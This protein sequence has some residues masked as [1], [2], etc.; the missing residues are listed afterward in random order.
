MSRYKI[1][2]GGY[3]EYNNSRNLTIDFIRGI[4]IL[5]VVFGHNIQYGSG[6]IFIQSDGYFEEILFKIIYS[7][8]MPLFALLSGYLFFCSIKKSV[9]TVL[10]TRLTSLL[11]PIVCWVALE[12]IVKLIILLILCRFNIISFM[13]DFVS[14]AVYR[15]WFLWAI[16]W[17]SMIVLLVEKIFKGRVWIYI[18][19][20]FL[21][22][23]IPAKYNTQM[24]VYMYPYFV[25]GFLFNKFEGKNWY[26]RIV[27]KDWIALAVA[28]VVFVVLFLFYDHDSY[29]YTTGIN[30][31]A[32]RSVLLQLG[33]DI[34]RWIIGF[35]GSAFVIVLCKMICDKGQGYGVKLFAYFGQISLGIYILNSYVNSYVLQRI[36]RNFSP[37]VF[38]WIV[39]TI[40]SMVF[41]AVAVEIIKKVPAAN[42]LLL[43]GR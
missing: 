10:K 34:Y 32:K 23:F 15:L 16:F 1:N 33:I 29:I 30:I 18:V 11:L 22:L 5:L 20:M 38:I 9:K 21:L 39:E 37:N 35:V 17:C 26:N 40:V 19:I 8:H 14:S 7:F 28:G 42:K 12:Y 31:L 24:Y 27:K 6:E 2:G 41:Y 36:T 43:G 4:A 25:A 3:S 13:H